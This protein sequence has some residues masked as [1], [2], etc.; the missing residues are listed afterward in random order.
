MIGKGACPRHTT[1]RSIAA[2]LG[3]AVVL[4]HDPAY[5]HFVGLLHGHAQAVVEDEQAFRSRRV[6]VRTKLF[7]EEAG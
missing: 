1:T 2:Q 6:G 5:P 3:Q 4:G 7:H